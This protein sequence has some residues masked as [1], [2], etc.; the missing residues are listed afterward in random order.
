MELVTDFFECRG[1]CSFEMH[2]LPNMHVNDDV[3]ST[4]GTEH[5]FEMRHWFTNI[6]EISNVII[7]KNLNYFCRKRIQF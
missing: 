3:D 2:V 4:F 6:Y 7:L 5:G 1:T